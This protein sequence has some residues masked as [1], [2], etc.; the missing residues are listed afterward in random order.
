ML[1]TYDGE[2][3]GEQ[4]VQH[5]SEPPKKDTRERRSGNY[6]DSPALDLLCGQR[7]N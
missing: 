1:N 4:F 6:I 5:L 2:Y 7:K 3:I